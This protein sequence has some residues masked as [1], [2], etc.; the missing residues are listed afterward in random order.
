MDKRGKKQVYSQKTFKLL[1]NQSKTYISLS[2]CQ[3]EFK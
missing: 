1:Q 3:L 2:L